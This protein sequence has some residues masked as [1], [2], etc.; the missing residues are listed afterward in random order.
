[1]LRGGGGI[2]LLFPATKL[3]QLTLDLCTQPQAGLFQFQLFKEN[4]NNLIGVMM[5]DS[6]ALIGWQ[7]TMAATFPNY[8]VKH[9]GS[10]NLAGMV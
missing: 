8:E 1:M 3:P 10:L 4:T 6:I 2:L 5:D 9:R 7:V